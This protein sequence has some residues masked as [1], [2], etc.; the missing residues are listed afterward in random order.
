[1]AEKC[2]KCGLLSTEVAMRCEC[3]YDFSSGKVKTVHSAPKTTKSSL[4]NFLEKSP[5]R[6]GR[7]AR[8][9]IITGIIII[10]GSCIGMLLGVIEIQMAQGTISITKEARASSISK[11]TITVMLSF[12]SLIVGIM[13]IVAK[14]RSQKATDNFT[15]WVGLSR[16]DKFVVYFAIF[17]GV[18]GIFILVFG[19]IFAVLNG[20]YICLAI[21]FL[22]LLVIIGTFMPKQGRIT[23]STSVRVGEYSCQNCGDKRAHRTSFGYFCSDRCQEQYGQKLFAYQKDNIQSDIERSGGHIAGVGGLTSTMSSQGSFKYCQKC[24]NRLSISAQKCAKCGVNQG[25]FRV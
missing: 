13:M 5:L 12:L 19:N 24:G 15:K 4:D 11:N 22:P 6:H 9:A 18:A 16:S 14:R 3:G 25:N 23:S 21:E 8:F 10:L 17:A 2:P 1:M 7:F 20:N